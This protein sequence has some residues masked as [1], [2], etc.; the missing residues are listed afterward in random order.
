MNWIKLLFVSLITL[1]LIFGIAG[2][3]YL[4]SFKPS[5]TFESR[6]QIRTTKLIDNPIISVDLHPSLKAESDSLGYTNINGPSLIR[7]PD[8]VEDPFGKY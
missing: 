3:F 6:A 5:Y 1:S 2:Y 4:E 8:W 7:V